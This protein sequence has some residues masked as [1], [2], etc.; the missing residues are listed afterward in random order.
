ME[1][2]LWPRP[3]FGFPGARTPHLR[4]RLCRRRRSRCVEDAILG[5]RN[6]PP[7]AAPVGPAA[8]TL[9]RPPV[10]GG[11]PRVAE[12]A[13]LT[14]KLSQRGACVFS[15]LHDGNCGVDGLAAALEHERVYSASGGAFPLTCLLPSGAEWI[16]PE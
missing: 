16:P 7:R 14:E 2:P 6:P 8:H 3:A 1:D 13:E 5:G 9:H 15:L 4:P 11:R 10:D 12:A